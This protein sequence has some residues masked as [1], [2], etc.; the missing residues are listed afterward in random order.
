MERRYLV[1]ALAMITAFAATSH[2]FRALQQMSVIH[3]RHSG[4]MAHSTHEPNCASRALAKIRT[5]LR[6]RYPEEAQL[7]AEMNVPLANMETTIEEQMARQNSAVAQ[8]ATAQAIRDADRARRD[9][10]RM[11]QNMTHA[12]EQASLGPM[13]LEMNLPSDLD[14]RIN[15]ALASRMAASNVKLQVLADKL[16]QSSMRIDNLDIPIVE[17]TDDGGVPS[18]L[19]VHVRCNVNNKA[20][21][22]QPQ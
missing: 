9:A 8:C 5:H 11:Q 10:M 4:A 6:P 20:P 15:A 12:A 16:R 3:A 19:H 1:A 18:H 2:G 17:V 13:A 7:L 21:R 14:Q 22:Q